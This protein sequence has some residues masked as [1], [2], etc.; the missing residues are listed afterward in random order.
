MELNLLQHRP[1]Q[2]PAALSRGG[3]RSGRWIDNKAKEQQF[4]YEKKHAWQ[5]CLVAKYAAVSLRNVGRTLHCHCNARCNNN[6]VLT[7]HDDEDHHHHHHRISHFYFFFPQKKRSFE[8]FDKIAILSVPPIKG[9]THI[10]CEI[11]SNLV[12]WANATLR[13]MEVHNI[14]PWICSL[15]GQKVLI[16]LLLQRVLKFSKKK[17]WKKR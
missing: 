9:V 4:D 11:L 8:S 2:S 16:R 5:E 12:P 10:S 1:Q 17:V 13:R 7:N 3:R 6:I 15:T 14:L